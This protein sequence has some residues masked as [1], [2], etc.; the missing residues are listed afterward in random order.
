MNLSP[1]DLV[2]IVAAYELPPIETPDDTVFGALKFVIQILQLPSKQYTIRV[3]RKERVNVEPA[4]YEERS[5][6]VEKMTAEILVADD[7]ID[8]ESITESS[9]QKALLRAL[10]GL[11]SVL[12]SSCQLSP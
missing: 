9:E 8:W 2:K 4:Y 5:E 12:G 1:S 6:L 3:M 7:S 11:Q 10:R